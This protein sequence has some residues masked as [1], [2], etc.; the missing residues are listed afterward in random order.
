MKENALC[1]A[2]EGNSSLRRRGQIKRGAGKAQE[3]L[4]E[5]TKRKVSPY[6]GGGRTLS[7]SSYAAFMLYCLLC[8]RKAARRYEN[9]D[10]M[11]FVMRFFSDEMFFFQ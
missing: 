11:I 9:Y 10:F 2:A 3:T 7:V 8:C 5:L 4:K 6:F 1:A